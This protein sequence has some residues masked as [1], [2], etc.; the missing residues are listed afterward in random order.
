MWTTPRNLGPAGREGAAG[1]AGLHF[2][3][4][5]RPAALPRGRRDT[6]VAEIAQFLHEQEQSLVVGGIGHVESIDREDLLLAR[7]LPLN[8]SRSL[9][10][11]NQKAYCRRDEKVTGDRR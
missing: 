4:D 2:R 11:A 5:L 7:A 1:L 6:H 3:A 9:S 8:M 10:M